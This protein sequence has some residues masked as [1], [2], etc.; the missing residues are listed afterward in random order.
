MLYFLKHNHESLS[1]LCEMQMKPL[2]YVAPKPLTCLGR[3]VTWLLVIT[4]ASPCQTHNVVASTKFPCSSNILCL[5]IRNHNHNF[6]VI[7]AGLSVILPRDWWVSSLYMPFSLVFY[8]N[9]LH[10]ASTQFKF[11]NKWNLLMPRLSSCLLNIN[12]F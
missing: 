6:H 4:P 9:A 1:N 7:T 2:S 12:Y 11:P 5:F 10:T 3:I 8:S